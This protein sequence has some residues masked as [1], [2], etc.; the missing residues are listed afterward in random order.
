M[1][2]PLDPLPQR[3]IDPDQISAL[4]AE[5]TLGNMKIAQ[6][7]CFAFDPVATAGPAP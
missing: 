7:Q 2:P 6:D 5:I 3:N 4:G 1:A